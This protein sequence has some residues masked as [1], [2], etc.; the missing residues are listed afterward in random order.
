MRVAILLLAV[1]AGCGGAPARVSLAEPTRAPRASDYVNTLKRWTRHGHLQD[2]FDSA[3]DVDATMHSPEFRAVFAE[4]WIE[5]FRIGPVD[6]ARV[7]SELRSDG[8]D[9]F[10]FHVEMQT[11]AYELNDLSSAK[12]V[13]RVALVDDRGREVLP[14][15]IMAG[16]QR[17]ALDIAFYP[18]ADIFSR[19]WRLRF[20]QRLP[21]GEPLV[22]PETKSLT[23]RFAGP[24][25]SVDLV[26]ALR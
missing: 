2:E 9:T 4:K 13:W 6:A 1:A 10:E 20:P 14:S 26:W 24:P 22:G 7:R 3:L 19:G 5:V 8:A 18:Y 15:D 11:H 23:L 17:R 21:G 25:G 12:A 16:K